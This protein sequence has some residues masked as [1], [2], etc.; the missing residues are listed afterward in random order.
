MLRSPNDCN[1]YKQELRRTGKQ[2]LLTDT[3]TTEE[4]VKEII[5]WYGYENP[6]WPLQEE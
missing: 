4:P 2:R 3:S 5:I 6:F 1:K